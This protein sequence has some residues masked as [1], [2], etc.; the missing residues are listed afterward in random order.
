MIGVSPQE[1]A[2][3]QNLTVYENL[4]LMAG[5]HGFI[6]RERKQKVVQMI[7][8][9][10]LTEY[11]HERSKTLSGGWKRR[12]SIAMALMSEPEVL[13]L[14]EP[15]LGLDAIARRE[16]WKVIEGLRGTVTFILTTHYLEEAQSLS[17]RICIL[18]QG[19][20]K[21]LGTAEQ[22]MTMTS[23]ESFEEAFITLAGGEFL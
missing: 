1:T 17:D 19:E 15:T 3:A 20:V 22:L 9:F 8:R 13:F 2:V 6:K 5:I 10:S 4:E 21:A 7:E 11:Q 12:L 16:L 18:K 14:D 23:T